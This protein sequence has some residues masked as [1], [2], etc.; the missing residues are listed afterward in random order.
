[1][2][3]PEPSGGKVSPANFVL[4]LRQCVVTVALFQAHTMLRERVW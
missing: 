4:L 3:E 2:S 1:M